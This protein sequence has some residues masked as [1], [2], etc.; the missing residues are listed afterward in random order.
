LTKA[1]AYDPPGTP[2]ARF[3]ANAFVTLGHFYLDGIPDS[4]VR[5]DATVAYGMFRHAA[6]YFGD[7]EAQYQVGRMHLMGTGTPKDPLQAARWLRLAADLGQ[8]HAQAL[9]GSMLFQGTEVPRQASMGLFWLAVAKDG[10]V[11]DGSGPADQWITDT[12]WT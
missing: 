10:V 2:Y 4:E 3:V 5:A 11:R 8:R 9:L 1:H 7:R 6:T 12:Y